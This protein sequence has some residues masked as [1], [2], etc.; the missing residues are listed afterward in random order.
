MRETESTAKTS[1]NRAIHMNISRKR[2]S[3]RNRSTPPSLTF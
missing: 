3:T 1:D 2:E